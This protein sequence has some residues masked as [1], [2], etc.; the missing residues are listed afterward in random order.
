MVLNLA[1]RGII[2]SRRRFGRPEVDIAAL[3]AYRDRVKALGTAKHGL[4]YP[5]PQEP[6]DATATE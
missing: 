1:K 2:P 5:K 6:P 4:R 3:L